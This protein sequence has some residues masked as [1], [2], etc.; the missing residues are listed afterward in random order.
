MKP[1]RAHLYLVPIFTWLRQESYE[2]QVS[3]DFTV[4]LRAGLLGDPFPFLLAVFAGS[5]DGCFSYQE[6]LTAMPFAFLMDHPFIALL[7]VTHL[8][9]HSALFF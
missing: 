5:A 1:D 9:Y 4:S 3:Q 6:E 8:L 7:G 2:L